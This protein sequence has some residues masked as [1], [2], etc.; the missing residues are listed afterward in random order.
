MLSND[1]IT[2]ARNLSGE[3][4]SVTSEKY[5][6]VLSGFFKTK[7]GEY[8]EG[9]KFLG[10]KVPRIRQLVKKYCNN[11][12]FADIDNLTKSEWHEIRLAGFLLLVEQ[13]S[14]ANKKNDIQK[15]DTII[16]FYLSISTRANNWVLV[17]LTAPKILG[18]WIIKNPQ[19]ASILY[20]LAD[21]ENL[22]QQRI[23]IVAT[24]CLVKN[25]IF[26]HTMILAQQL[27]SHDHDLIHKAI[28][29]LLREVGKKDLNLLEKFLQENANIMHRTTLRYAIE[30]M[31]KE[32]KEYYMSIHK[33]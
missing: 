19:K 26:N 3:L 18:H 8:A 13:Y 10:I 32:K 12:T 20:T 30:R 9:D 21:S 1:N 24:L 29:W 17:D 23:S 4:L 31:P 16:Q 25:N 28:G 11:A 27:L 7:K 14:I 5:A 33:N 6:K 22:W 15:L 2:V